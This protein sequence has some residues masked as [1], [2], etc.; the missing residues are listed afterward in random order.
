MEMNNQIN[1]PKTKDGSFSIPLII[2]G[3]LGLCALIGTIIFCGVTFLF[4]RANGNLPAIL[5]TPVPTVDIVQEISADPSWDVLIDEEFTDNSREWDVSEY[6]ND[7]VKLERKITDGKYIWEFQSKNGWNFFT[8][9]NIMSVSDFAAT[10]EVSLTKGS[11][12]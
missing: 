8:Q 1:E 4:T 12:F 10:M 7:N 9:P 3:V 5:A 11:D 2:F 6:E